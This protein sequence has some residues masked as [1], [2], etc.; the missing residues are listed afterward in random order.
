VESLAAGM[1][2]SITVQIIKGLYR[3]VYELY[4]LAFIKARLHQSLKKNHSYYKKLGRDQSV[5]AR[6]VW[7]FIRENDFIPREDLKITFK[8]KVIIAS[9]AVQ[10]S[11][12]LNDTA[13]NFYEKIII[14]REYYTSRLT[15]RLH[16]AEVNPGLKL[17]VFSVRAIH[18]SLTREDDGINVLLHEFAHALWLEHLLMHKHYAV[19]SAETFATVKRCIEEQFTRSS[20]DEAHLFR[21]Y[22]FTNEAEFF[23]VA[24]ENFF[25]R[26]EKFQ[27]EL[28]ELYALLTKLFR[29]DPM[30]IKMKNP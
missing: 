29:Q 20:A 30:R 27:S 10:L 5:F 12:R 9:H 7:A 2:E 16:K 25:E 13:Y 28:P 15:N 14:Y 11:W 23:A 18:E 26:P 17:I 6:K 19:F 24:V 21:K 8:L 4:Y 3:G 1:F 22:A